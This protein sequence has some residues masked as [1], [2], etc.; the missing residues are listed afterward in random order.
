VRLLKKTQVEGDSAF[1][2]SLSPETVARDLVTDRFV[3]K[4]IALNGG[5]KAFNLP[6]SFNRRELI[7]FT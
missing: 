5:A 2:R 1:L 6:A 4:A 7:N 3:R